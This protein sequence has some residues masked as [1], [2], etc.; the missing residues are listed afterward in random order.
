MIT[1]KP[2]FASCLTGATVSLGISGWARRSIDI[3][4]LT[5][6]DAGD[7]GDSGSG[8]AG[9]TSKRTALAYQQRVTNQ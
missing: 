5:L 4:A 7:E 1:H 8:D 3:D 9:I 2:S 6:T